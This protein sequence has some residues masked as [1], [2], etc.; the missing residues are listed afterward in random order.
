MQKL[1]EDPHQPLSEAS[2]PLCSKCSANRFS[3]TP[4]CVL[5]EQTATMASKGKQPAAG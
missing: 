1:G 5:H 4:T 2:S 3:K